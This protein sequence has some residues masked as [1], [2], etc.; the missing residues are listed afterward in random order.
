[1]E[2]VGYLL[3]NAQQSLRA[4]MDAALRDLGVTTPQY[5]VMT[6][7]QESPGASSAQLARQAFVTPQTMIRIVANLE[8]AGL[9]ARDPHPDLGRV[10][11][12][13]LTKEGRGL[14]ARCQ[15]RVRQVEA[16]MVVDFSPDERQ[17]LADLLHRCANNLRPGGIRRSDGSRSA[18]RP[19]PY[20]SQVRP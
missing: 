12:A 2:A 6:F 20:G 10:L 16:R 9:I 7:L 3:K 8:A 1:M 11:E 4:A 18:S 15:R 5:A 19:A 17:Q 14:L 13:R